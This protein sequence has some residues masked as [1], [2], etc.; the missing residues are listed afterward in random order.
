MLKTVVGLCSIGALSVGAIA[1]H[2]LQTDGRVVAA[3]GDAVPGV[4][5]A[6][7]GGAG[8][9]DLPV[10]EANGDVLFRGRF[11]GGAV[12]AADE[13]AFFR[14]TPTGLSLLLRGGD[15]APGL[16]GGVTLS[17][18]S[19][20]S[21]LT[22]NYRSSSAGH[23]MAVT[24]LWNG[25]VTD[26]DNAAILAGP[27]S[28]LSILVRELDS[29]PGTVGAQFASDF[30]SAT[31]I[32][33]GSI[34][35]NS[36]GQYLFKSLLTGGDVV[37]TTNNDGWW[38]GAPGSLQLLVRK[39]DVMPGG[40]GFVMNSITNATSP[41]FAKL[42]AAGQVLWE[43]IYNSSV[44][45]PLP[46][47]TTN[48]VLYL[49]TVGGNHTL[50]AREGDPAPGLVGGEVYGASSGASVWGVTG[51]SLDAHGNVLF[52]SDLRGGATSAD[53]DSAV[54]Y[55]PSGGATQLVFRENDSLPALSNVNVAFLTN[56]TLQLN[57]NGRFVCMAALRGA[58]VTSTSDSAVLAG[59]ATVAG[60][61]LEVI[62]REGDLAPDTAAATFSAFGS[63]LFA[64]NNLGTAVFVVGLTGGDTVVGVN[65][66]ALYSWTPAGGLTLIARKGDTMPQ[67]ANLPIQGWSIYTN[68]NGAT[69]ALG[70]NHANRLVLRL[71][72]GSNQ[73]IVVYDVPQAT[74]PTSYCTAGT[75]TNGCLASLSASGA[76]SIA[77]ASGF[78][79]DVSNVE[80]Q[81]T[82]LVFYGLDNSGFT[83]LPWSSGS[84]SFLC[85][86]PPTQR[87]GSQS[88]GGV[89]GQCNGAFAQ[90][91]LA[92]LAANPG[93]LGEPFAA[94]ASVYAQAWFRDPPAA[95][96][97]NLSNALEFVTL[98]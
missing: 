40:G 12:S 32:T 54:F 39:G 87:M 20:Q 4:P 93:A 6:V 11:F 21:G 19:G 67:L 3:G 31:F 85:V 50:V 52:R 48:Q 82:G 33:P 49:S 46:T 64:F 7:F 26:N 78:T 77:A 56:G 38:L 65:D 2:P 17:T 91:W 81:K 72:V 83:P 28:N 24:S 9:F 89:A 5:G 73:A 13:R 47:G 75:T 68:D 30:T 69:T 61:A 62:A 60:G 41:Y 80:G 1:Q 63:A 22:S 44:G 25:G 58:A 29:A 14:S 35:A 37:G 51:T 97:T 84:N 57:D 18:S 45:S 8:W 95:K 36:A 70:F 42:N 34:A 90:D 96:S 86:K 53:N 98:P 43:G 59:N 74:T 10:V 79:I 16:S 15:P 76:P 92:Y 88:S 66:A 71:I 23:L 94:G 55:R 27:P